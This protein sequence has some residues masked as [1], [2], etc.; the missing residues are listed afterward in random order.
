MKK[1]LLG[2]R[3][4]RWR[5]SHW[6]NSGTPK[7]LYNIN[8]DVDDDAAAAGAPLRSM[9]TLHLSVQQNQSLICSITIII[10]VI[11]LIGTN[12]TWIGWKSN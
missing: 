9:S 4:K 8:D 3:H 1:A 11:A 12:S 10:T 2:N 5:K 6:Q 7:T